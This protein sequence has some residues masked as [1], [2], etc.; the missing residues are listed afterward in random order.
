[1]CEAQERDERDQKEHP[2]HEKYADVVYGNVGENNICDGIARTLGGKIYDIWL[3]NK[4]ADE[5]TTYRKHGREPETLLRCIVLVTPPELT[6]R[7][8][9]TVERCA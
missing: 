8:R 3:Y 7:S 4:N 9:V 2:V 1:M 5:K 6:V